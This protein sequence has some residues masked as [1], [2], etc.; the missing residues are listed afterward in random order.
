[1][2]RLQRG[3]TGMSGNSGVSRIG[4]QS[5]IGLKAESN[6]GFEELKVTSQ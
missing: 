6:K 5:Q 3:L 4:S 1:M 2:S